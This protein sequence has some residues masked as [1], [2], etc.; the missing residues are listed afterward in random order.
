MMKKGKTIVLLKHA[1]KDINGFLVPLCFF[2]GNTQLI[3]KRSNT[4]V[5]EAAGVQIEI[6]NEYIIEKPRH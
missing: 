3:E 1:T 2:E 4:S 6:L 5:I